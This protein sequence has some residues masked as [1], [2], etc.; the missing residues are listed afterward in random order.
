MRKIRLVLEYRLGKKVSAQ[1]TAKA[2][3][4]SKGSVIN[5]LERF[6]RSQLAWPLPDTLT[7]TALEDAL[8][9]CCEQTDTKITT[10]LPDIAYI[11]KELARPHVTLQRLWEE[12]REQHPDSLSRTAFYRFVARS[13]SYPVTMHM[14]HKGGDK[15]FVDYSGDGL[16]YVDRTTGESI[17]TQLFVC[18]WGASSYAYAEATRTQQVSD[19]VQSHVRGLA[20]FGVVPRAF[21]P[22]NLKS[23]VKKPDRYDPIAN[24]LY[25]K[26][27][28]HY[29]VAIL[30]ARVRKPQDK[31][32][33]ESNVLHIQR[34]ILARLRDRQFFS[35]DEINEAI[36]E[37]LALFNNRPMKEHGDKTRKQRF[38]EL[39]HPNA[40]PLPVE[41]FILSRVELGVRAAPNYHVC[42]EKH[43][44]SVPHHLAR[45]HVDI[46]QVGV[47]LEMYHNHQHICRHLVQPSNYGYTTVTEHMPPHHAFI[48]GWSQEWF[49]GQAGQIGPAT[50]EAV[51]RI[52]IARQHVQQGFNAAMGVLKLAKV[53]TPQRLEQAS[54][55]ALHF[56]TANYRTIKTILEQCLDKQRFLP[57]PQ[58]QEQ[59]LV[60]ANIRGASYYATL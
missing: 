8:F 1:L 51:K 31:A 6:A 21:V 46:Y 20:Y 47:I 2:L 5:Y 44:Y 52:M 26:M 22:D 54:Q 34:F 19:F 32:V 48:K 55:R 42:F 14:E 15:L 11:E 38:D 16:A 27:A 33:A 9:P 45:C 49:I 43:Y 10:A 23:G 24:P 18:A 36:R 50:A 25:E 56:N 12:Y 41:R 53:Y 17:A 13:R 57:L 60:H 28:S 4:L 39:D 37:E 40:N 30:P 7:D 35:L 59:P 3:S 29:G 58:K